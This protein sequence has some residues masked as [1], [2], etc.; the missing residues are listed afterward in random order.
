[1]VSASH[2]FFDHTADVGMRVQADSLPLLFEQAA[3][4][5]V[6]LLV[7]SSQIKPQE[8]RSIN[9]T[10]SSTAELLRLW[11]TEVLVWFDTD[12]FI[13]SSYN[14][15]ITGDTTLRGSVQGERFD[16]PRHASGTEVKGI[17]RHQFQLERADGHWEAQ[18][19]FDV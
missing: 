18:V 5:L 2:E 15:E 3:R 7:E 14:L 6:E 11:L 4:G 1:M 13:P 10:G 19:I 9:L 16:P 12:R 17:T 8:T